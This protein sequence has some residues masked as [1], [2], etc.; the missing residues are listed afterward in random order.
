LA[1]LSIGWICFGGRRFQSE[2]EEAAGMRAEV[3]D[4]FDFATRPN[5]GN[6]T[7]DVSAGIGDTGPYTPVYE[8]CFT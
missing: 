5:R 2:A 4:F 6:L 8:L 1:S 3:S 7:L